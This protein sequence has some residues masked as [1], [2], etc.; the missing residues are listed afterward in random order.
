MLWLALYGTRGQLLVGIL[1]AV[2]VFLVPIVWL[3]APRYPPEEWQTP[4]MWMVV[5]AIVGIVVHELV[6]DVRSRSARGEIAA[7]LRTS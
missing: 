2:A 7:S 5:A 3:G 1:G 4:T 6:R